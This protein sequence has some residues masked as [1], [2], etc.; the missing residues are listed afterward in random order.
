MNAPDPNFPRDFEKRLQKYKTGLTIVWSHQCP[1][2]GKSLGEIFETAKKKGIKFRSVELKTPKAAQSAPT[3]YAVF[4]ILYDGQVMA[5]H[6]VS[7]TR[8]KN[9]LKQI[10]L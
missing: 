6:M 4:S 10:G 2:I 9:I 1:Y 8:F 5:D 3:P 7:N